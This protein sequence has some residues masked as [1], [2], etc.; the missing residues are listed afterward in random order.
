MPTRIRLLARCQIND[1]VYQAGDIV[2]LPD[3]QR[4][5]HRTVVSANP[6]S[7]ISASRYHGDDESDP[8]YITQDV[9]DEPLFVVVDEGVEKEREEMRARHIEELQKL[10]H[11]TERR[12]LIAKQNKESADLE[13]K[14]QDTELQ[15]KQKRED[16][17]LKA[18]QD[19][20]NASFEKREK[21]PILAP[22]PIETTKETLETRHKVELEAQKSRHEQDKKALEARKAER[23]QRNTDQS[24]PV[25]P[26]VTPVKPTPFVPQPPNP[27]VPPAPPPSPYT[28]PAAPFPTNKV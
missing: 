3:G 10:D 13:M 15:A 14:A 4:G 18:R 7:Q 8:H 9:N 6:G 23:D 25:K 22:P 17:S 26:D 12:D 21:E 19:S 16:D 28:P 27:Y 24:K 2:T 20:E 11:T 5:P 1:S